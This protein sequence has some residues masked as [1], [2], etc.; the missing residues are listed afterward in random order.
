MCECGCYQ[1]IEYLYK[2]RLSTGEWLVIGKYPGC[3]YCDTPIGITFDYFDSYEL[4]NQ[5]LLDLPILNKTGIPLLCG[6]D[7]IK[8]IINQCELFGLIKFEDKI[9]KETW[10]DEFDVDSIAIELLDKIKMHWSG[11]E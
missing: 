9:D 7:I 5:E 8:T 1:R 10:I 3:S 6:K 11:H 2:I 4:E